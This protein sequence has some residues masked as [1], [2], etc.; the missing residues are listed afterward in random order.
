M[1][2]LVRIFVIRPSG[3]FKYLIFC[4]IAI[5]F[6]VSGVRNTPA[7]GVTKSIGLFFAFYLMT[8]ILTEVLSNNATAVLLTPIGLGIA[9]RA[10][11]R[12]EIESPIGLQVI[13]RS[14][15]RFDPADPIGIRGRRQPG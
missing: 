2:R 7:V 13:L 11:G 3:P 1:L 8:S 4:G 5:P 10:L 9:E 6:A 12:V 15:E 14:L